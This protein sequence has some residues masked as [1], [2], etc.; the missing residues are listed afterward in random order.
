MKEHIPHCVRRTLRGGQ[1]VPTIPDL[2][3]CIYCREVVFEV[4]KIDVGPESD[5]TGFYRGCSFVN[6]RPFH[7][8]RIPKER[9]IRRRACVRIDRLLDLDRKMRNG[10]ETLVKR[11]RCGVSSVEYRPDEFISQKE[12]F[13]RWINRSTQVRRPRNKIIVGRVRP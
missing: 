7:E 6:K 5:V 10:T 8:H 13:P 12:G 3:R 2:E 11:M 4:V 9:R 1:A